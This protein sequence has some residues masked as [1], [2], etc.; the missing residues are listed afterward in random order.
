M[1]LNLNRREV[2]VLLAEPITLNKSPAPASP[3]KFPLKLISLKVVFSLS[4]SANALAPPSPILLSSIFNAVNVLLY[5]ITFDKSSIPS[6]P[7]L[8][9]L[10]SML[11]RVRLSNIAEANVEHPS[12][13]I[14]FLLRS[15][16]TTC[17]FLPRASNRGITSP[18][19][20]F[21]FCSSTL[22]REASF[23]AI[24]STISLISMTFP[25]ILLRDTLMG[26]I[27]Y[28]SSTVHSFTLSCIV[29][30]SVLCCCWGRVWR[31]RRRVVVVVVVGATP[32]RFWERFPPRTTGMVV[33]M[34]C[35]IFAWRSLAER[36]LSR[37]ISRR[38]FCLS[39]WTEVGT[40]GVG[41]SVAE[42][43]WVTSDGSRVVVRRGLLPWLE[44]EEE[45]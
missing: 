4:D 5:G 19:V 37:D 11:I 25:V 44:E 45:E 32:C 40:E 26:L 35:F 15:K 13:P 1:A 36:D 24:F 31:D 30:S 27:S 23:R 38:A 42:D 28:C 22:A 2:T 43:R 33:C 17:S 39:F 18:S 7:K 14:R 6:S 16:L 34:I 10:T 8:F 3:I 29:C 20:R 12:I 21:I 41:V 9:P